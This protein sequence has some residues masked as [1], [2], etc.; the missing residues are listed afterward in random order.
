MEGA[1]ITG[2]AL[3]EDELEQAFVRMDSDHGGFVQFDEFVQ[4]ASKQAVAAAAAAAAAAAQAPSG[5][6]DGGGGGD[7][8]LQ[9]VIGS[10]Y[11][12]LDSSGAGSSP[13]RGRA[14]GVAGTSKASA[15]EMQ[16]ANEEIARIRQEYAARG[17]GNRRRGRGVI[18]VG[19]VLTSFLCH[20]AA[21]SDM[22]V[23]RVFLLLQVREEVI[24]N[25]GE[26]SGSPE[27]C[28]VSSTS[29]STPCS[30]GV[31]RSQVHEARLAARGRE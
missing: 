14:R 9:S 10:F 7:D 13:A 3:S 2:L 19:H 17:L 5:D 30:L 12:G 20:T 27:P 25:P 15:V 24:S 11:R 28:V 29:C 6:E 21:A 26:L 4:F 18:P 1:K 8:S 31:S 23:F 22:F 16:L